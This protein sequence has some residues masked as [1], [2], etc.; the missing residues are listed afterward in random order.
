[1]NITGEELRK[2]ISSGESMIVDMYADWCGPCRVLGPIVERFSTKLKEEG[3]NVSVYK[4]NIETDR[5][6]AAEL[7]VRSIPTI[8]GFKG[9]Q[10]MITKVGVLQES[11]LRE[12][13]QTIL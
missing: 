6:L 9:G 12:M 11:Q 2:R 10:E 7:G 5:E 13:E 4:F 8:K 3:S 1:M